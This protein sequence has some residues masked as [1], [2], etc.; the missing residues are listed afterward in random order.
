MAKAPDTATRARRLIALLPLLRKG[1]RVPIQDLAS[2]VGCS[3]EEVVSDLTT[4]TLCG[5]PPFS[6][7]DLVDLEIDGDMVAVYMDPPG[8]DR[9]LRLTIPEARALGAALEVA[10]YAPDSALRERIGEICSASVSADEL[11]RTVRIS[12]SPG[13]AA[14]VYATLAAAADAHEKLRISYY[15]GS[16]G[17]ISERVVHPWLL[18]QRQG[19]WYL[20]GL[21]EAVRQERVF[22]LDRIREIEH[23]GETFVPPGEI[24][25]AVT[26][27]VA[28]LPVA[29]IR[30][31]PDAILPEER[32]WPGVTFAP[33]PDGSTVARVPYQSVSW[34]AR[35]VV[36]YLGGAEVLAP[37]AVRRGV[38]AL[39]EDV[40]RQVG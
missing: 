11:E 21:C 40:L 3:A 13:G 4:L 14:Q 18:V 5:I 7:M 1:E 37:D 39:A 2:A 17:R 9:P 12:A 20:V 26:P 33:Q 6:P 8:L 22:R 24:S 10:G 28:D 36:A 19:T 25:S 16:T 29:E 23:T 35:R 30:F 32:A 34:I 38:R 31:A 27:A 15:T